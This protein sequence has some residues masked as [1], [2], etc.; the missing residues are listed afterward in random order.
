[1]S[2]NLAARSWS[3]ARVRQY[4]PELQA[5][6]AQVLAEA[7]GML[8]DS[9]RTGNVSGEQ[10]EHLLQTAGGEGA[11]NEFTGELLSRTRAAARGGATHQ[12]LRSQGRYEGF[13]AKA[14]GRFLELQSGYPLLVPPDH[15][16]PVRMSNARLNTYSIEEYF[17]PVLPNERLA[18]QHALPPAAPSPNARFPGFT[19]EAALNTRT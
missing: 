19:A 16:Y 8:R 15:I 17:L 18:W 9:F 6:H 5:R 11:L 13:S 4:S 14:S 7:K 12:L 10:F 2:A 1:M 3:G